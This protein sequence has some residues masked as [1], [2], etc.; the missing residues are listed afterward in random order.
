MRITIAALALLSACT[1]A[2]EPAPPPISGVAVTA[3]CGGGVT[4]GSQGVTITA[5]DHIVRW[6]QPTT[7]A[8]RTETDLGADAVIAADVRHQLDA[9]N[10]AQVQ[11]NEAGN[12]TC[13]LTAGDHTVAWPQ[14]AANAPSDVVRVHQRVF[15]ADAG[16]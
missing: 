2:P 6:R 7:Q 9:M 3:S 14:G 10:F 5:Q 1:A 13:A 12:M 4:G 11:H 15:E 8:Q 16:N